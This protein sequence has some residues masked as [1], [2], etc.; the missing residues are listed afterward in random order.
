MIQEFKDFIAKGNV[1]QMPSNAMRDPNNLLMQG[2]DG[3]FTERADIAGVGIEER[4]RGAAMAD[5][6]GDGRLDLVVGN[7]RAPMELWQ[8]ET[9]A[10]GAWAAVQ[11]VAPSPN[12]QAITAWVE[13]R[14]AGRVHAREVT[15][16][17]GHGGGQ[18]GPLHFGLGDAEAAEVRVLWPGQGWSDWQPLATNEVTELHPEP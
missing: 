11:L 3:V 17:D 15:V 14:S 16:G 6:D 7:R 2:A 1:D 18:A 8:N 5:F 13:V 4:S 9:E 12:T 10:A